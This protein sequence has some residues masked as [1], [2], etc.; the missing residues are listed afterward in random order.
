[1]ID[2]FRK[3]GAVI[4]GRTNCPAFSY[5]WFTTN[6]DPRRHQEPARSLDHAGRLVR[7]RGCGGRGRHR[8]IS[9]TAPT[10]RARSAIPPTPA[11]CMA[12]GR[13]SAASPP[14]IRRCPSAPSGRRSGGVRP[15]GAHHRAT[16]GSR[17]PRCRRAIRAIPGGCR[18]RWKGRAMPKRAALCLNPDGLDP[19]AE[20]KAA[21]G[22][23]RPSGWSARAGRSRK[24][25]T[26]RRC[27]SRGLAT[28]N[29]GSATC[30]EAQ[31]A[32]AEKRG[33]SRRAR[34]P[35][36]QPRQG[37]A[38]RPGR[39]LQGADAP[40]DADARM[41]ACSWRNMPCC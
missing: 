30:Y 38:V 18:R 19:V 5:R 10:S 29:S 16:C 7:R 32:T 24:L 20:V 21:R 4:L 36:R 23:R 1:M 15:A 31:L 25:R 34:L 3:A 13:R 28:G 41:D 27:A 17:S 33:R 11:A 40:R 14:S 2:N 39:F 37:H 12:C 9:R 6:L 8:R 35:A 26:R 22:R